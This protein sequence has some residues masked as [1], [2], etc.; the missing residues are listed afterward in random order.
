MPFQQWCNAN[1]YR[2]ASVNQ[3]KEAVEKYLE[4]SPEVMATCRPPHTSNS[5]ANAIYQGHAGPNPMPPV[6]IAGPGGAMIPNP[7][8]GLWKTQLIQRIDQQF[9]QL[10]QQGAQQITQDVTTANNARRLAD[11]TVAIPSGV[12]YFDALLRN[13]YPLAK[14]HVVGYIDYLIA[15]INDYINDA[16]NHSNR[17]K[18]IRDGVLNTLNA[19][20]ANVNYLP[21]DRTLDAGIFNKN[22]PG[23]AGGAQTLADIAEY[24]SDQRTK[25]AA[26]VQNFSNACAGVAGG[27]VAEFALRRYGSTAEGEDI[28]QR[29]GFYQKQ[30][31][32]F[33]QYKWFLDLGIRNATTSV[34]DTDRAFFVRLKT[35][36]L[37]ALRGLEQV[38]N[39]DTE[40]P[41]IHKPDIGGEVGCFGVHEDCLVAFN[42]R[43]VGTIQ[44]KNQRTNS[45]MPPDVVAG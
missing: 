17:R 23:A 21:A 32:S 5:R 30:G 26:R 31:V 38:Y 16:V 4:S 35:G 36:V 9:T 8:L 3:I 10:A 41:V 6:Q 13:N 34:S 33:E 7:A 20:K 40:P 44:I 37:N 29:L 11:A 19:A 25:T 12:E 15:A 43:M 2:P 1:G 14:A 28:R 18:R 42:T 45:V 24:W 27:V 22:I 39:R